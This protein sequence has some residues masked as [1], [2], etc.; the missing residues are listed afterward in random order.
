VNGVV[1]VADEITLMR[2][3]RPP[4]GFLRWFMGAVPT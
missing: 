1:A 3:Y 4:G 2:L